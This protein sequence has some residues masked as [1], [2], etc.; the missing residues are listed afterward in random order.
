LQTEHPVR[1]V[2][3]TNALVAALAKPGG[4]AARIVRAWRDGRLE[5]VASEATLREAELVLGA[6]WLLRVTSREEVDG[7]LHDLRDRSVRVT[8]GKVTGLRL[9]DEGDRRLVEAAVGGDAD[10]L[11][12]ADREVL[13]SRG[14]GGTEFVTPGEFLKVLR[15]REAAPP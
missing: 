3:D 11:V 10:Y 13:H 5:I 15:S 7:S 8:P 14:Y 2:V 1:I 12:T 9:R 4:S 6:G